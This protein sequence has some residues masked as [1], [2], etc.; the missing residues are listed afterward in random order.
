MRNVFRSIKSLF[1]FSVQKMWK[2]RGMYVCK[3]VNN[4]A[5]NDFLRTILLFKMWKK[6]TY[7]QVFLNIYTELS[8]RFLMKFFSVKKFIF[9]IF[10]KT[11]Y[12]EYYI[13]N[14]EGIK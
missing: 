11:Y 5:Q 14:K 6:P 1:N 8:S 13:F 9:H 2:N 10:H 12:D 4:F 7:S 3:F